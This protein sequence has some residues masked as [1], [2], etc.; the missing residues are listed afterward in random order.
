MHL[1]LSPHFDDAVFSCGGTIHQLA[2]DGKDV[3]MMTIMGGDPPHPLPGTP[4]VRNLHSRWNAGQAPITA[5]RNEDQ[6][7]AELL[8]V[9]VQHMDIPDCVYRT[10]ADGKPLYPD[11]A[12]L[13][14]QVHPDDP[15]LSHLEGFRVPEQVT[16]LYV[17][18]GVGAHV[19][20]LVVREIGIAIYRLLNQIDQGHKHTLL[21]YVEFPYNEKPDA[22]QA[23]QQSIPEDIHLVAHDVKLSHQNVNAKIEGIKAYQSQISTFWDDE[24]ALEKRVRAN[25]VAYADTPTEHYYQI[26]RGQ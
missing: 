17:P 13:W 2:Q 10:D 5:R 26:Q 6:R 15:V 21:F 19:D 18:M 23:A 3:L 8:G 7:A 9:R 14:G 20:H 16:H 24:A 1:F 11:E 12:S 25:L 22:V 4:I